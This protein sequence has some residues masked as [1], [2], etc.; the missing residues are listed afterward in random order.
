MLAFSF[1]EYSK[2]VPQRTLSF[3]KNFLKKLYRGIEYFSINGRFINAGNN[4]FDED[5]K[6]ALMLK[7]LYEHDTATMMSSC[8]YNNDSISFS[9]YRKNREMS[10][11]DYAV[12][13]EHYSYLF[14]L[15]N[16]KEE[17]TYL[18][19]EKIVSAI[20]AKVNSNHEHGDLIYSTFG[21]YN[22]TK[23]FN[24][25]L[26][27]TDQ[28]II[29]GIY[30]HHSNSF[31][32]F[33]D[34]TTI[35]Y[36]ETASKVFQYLRDKKD[37]LKVGKSNSDLSALSLLI[38]VYY[39]D[40]ISN[41]DN[42]SKKD[43]I[44]EMFK[45]N[46]ITL[47]SISKA[48]G[49]KG[50]HSMNYN[51]N[52]VILSSYFT[53][54]FKPGE[55]VEQVLERV[56]SRANTQSIVI[57][58]V[59][60]A[61]NCSID[62][63]KTVSDQ[64]SFSTRVNER[65]ES[66]INIKNKQL[67]ETIYNELP[68][69]T[70]DFMEFT[71]KI[72]GILLNKFNEK[73]TNTNYINSI[74]DLDTLALLISGYFYDGN[75]SKF[76]MHNG[77]TLDNIFSVLGFNI[78]KEYIDKCELDQNLMVSVFGRFIFDGVNKNKYHD[79]ISFNDILNNLCNRRFN[80]SSILKRIFMTYSNSSLDDDFF[81]QL[82]AFLKE[83]EQTRIYELTQSIY[84]GLPY[85]TVDFLDNV[86]R[87]YQALSKCGYEWHG[88]ELDIM[89]VLYAAIS[90]NDIYAL[91]LRDLGL[92]DAYMGKYLNISG[93]RVSDYQ[94]SIDIINEHYLSY[95]S[96]DNKGSISPEI[97]VSLVL[98][99][100]IQSSVMINRL[101]GNIMVGYETISD[102]ETVKSSYQTKKA[103]EKRTKKEKDI[104]N[105]CNQEVINYLK[106]VTKIDPKIR[107]FIVKNGEIS[108]IREAKDLEE[109]SMLLGLFLTNSSSIPFFVH[110][111]MDLITIL[112][113][114]GL[115]SDFLQDLSQ[116]PY[117][118]DILIEK[119]GKYVLSD[120]KTKDMTNIGK[121]LFKNEINDSFAIES[122]ASAV[123]AV[124][125]ILKEEVINGHYHVVDL[126]VS[127]RAEMLAK[128]PI[129]S[130]VVEDMPSI[131]R[132]GN[133]LTE[134]STFIHKELPRLVLGDTSK[135]ALQEIEEIISKLQLSRKDEPSG[136]AKFVQVIFGNPEEN[137]EPE[138][139]IDE[140][141]E[142]RS[143]IA[144]HE[145]ELSKETIAYVELF[146]YIEEYRRKCRL[147]Y[148]EASEVE[149]KLL[150][151]I[152]TLDPNDDGQYAAYLECT[153]ALQIIRNKKSRFATTNQLLKQELVKISQIIGNHSTTINALQMASGDFIPL[154]LTELTINRGTNAETKALR[155]SSSIIR[156]FESML[157]K[158]VDASTEMLEA[159]KDSGLSSE[160]YALL[161]QGLQ[162]FI[163]EVDS[164]PAI[165]DYETDEPSVDDD[166]VHTKK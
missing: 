11:S 125:D 117:S 126:T 66:Y 60:A 152:Q 29:N 81:K 27:A 84:G 45:D 26:V 100:G 72:Y 24:M 151:K 142:L 141:K 13:F 47:D 149:K 106:S 130:V 14:C 138:I 87:Y 153:T 140:I 113:N 78:T 128:E 9:Y 124:Y 59:L 137:V 7:T 163:E 25:T 4:F 51:A 15:Y 42:V 132:F 159:L 76:F 143:T 131:L 49:L 18:T 120:Y 139:D 148:L 83:S 41:K 154:I 111:G 161:E 36:M 21:N 156:L 118:P 43:I 28:E 70:I 2:T 157:H 92:T 97:L 48:I 61:C 145:L 103:L 10:N 115:P 166:F 133:S 127:E 90:S 37:E 1:E 6:Y 77:I 32:R 123:G 96:G 52:P 112:G 75:I 40:D 136:F 31:F 57:E 98:R 114:L 22:N 38:A 104:F 89:A 79:K 53:D 8:G 17:Y 121:Y 109:I 73:M 44:I 82:N 54:I 110:N 62:E 63:F 129:E 116:Y 68:G 23:N 102:I 101:L 50:L 164:T 155:L 58:R 80:N 46:N 93:I 5:S 86:S 144:A 146:K 34:I 12:L 19:P 39:Y 134:H 150:E 3:T 85:S 158:N 135:E 122:I 108:I 16:Y 107:D 162:H 88:K 74:D 99:D 69:K 95:I 33:S 119:Y 105:H 64:E 65:Y 30:R 165:S 56:F 20:L 55:S 35:N 91:A 67:I 147:Y 160:T 94:P 71:A